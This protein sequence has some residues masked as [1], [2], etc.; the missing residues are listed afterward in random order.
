MLRAA[1][2]PDLEPATKPSSIVFK[3]CGG[4]QRRIKKIEEFETK[5]QEAKLGPREKTTLFGKTLCSVVSCHFLLAAKD[6]GEGCKPEDG[7]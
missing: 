5:V 2:F 7:P 3:T 4:L 1:G 6:G